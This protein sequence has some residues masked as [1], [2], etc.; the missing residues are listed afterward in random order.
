MTTPAHRMRREVVR[1]FRT[2]KGLLILLLTGLIGPAQVVPSARLAWPGLAAAMAAAVLVDVPMLRWRKRRWEFPS[3]AVLTGMLVGMLMS[4]HEPWHV[5]AICSAAAV[6]LKY[7]VRTPSA[8]VFNPAAL[9]LVG[10]YYAFD[11]GHSWW[12]ALPDLTLASSL[13]L[14]FATGGFITWRV[15]KAPLVLMFLG[16]YYGLFTLAAFI[17]DPAH[18]AEVFI[19]PDLQAVLFFASF[20]LTDPPTS[21]TRYGDQLIYGAL[22]AVAAYATYELMGVVFY[23]LAGVL[24]GNVWEA[25]RR[26]TMHRRHAKRRATAALAS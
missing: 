14:L 23:L 18:V 22:V 12:G 1:F 9:A 4:P 21:P 2:P 16:T 11:A 8:N 17:G 3:G 5:G 15:N 25:G 10:A 19:A 7:I 13:P 6:A 20:I 26:L 24:V